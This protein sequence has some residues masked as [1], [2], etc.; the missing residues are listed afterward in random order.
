MTKTVQRRIGSG[1]PISAT[2]RNHYGLPVKRYKRLGHGV[3]RQTT[4]QMGSPSRAAPL[5]ASGLPKCNLGRRSYRKQTHYLLPDL[6]VW[7][8]G[9]TGRK[10]RVWNLRTIA[11][12][13]GQV[14]SILM[15]I[16]VKGVTYCDRRAP[17][18]ATQPQSDSVITRATSGLTPG[19]LRGSCDGM[20]GS[21]LFHHHH[22][23]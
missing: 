8:T 1:P 16:C 6:I 12:P 18:C 22:T 2:G 5:R 19:Q 10:H 17:P 20:R 13:K 9:G 23:L 3:T 11:Y 4:F 21:D 7:S 14:F 15:T